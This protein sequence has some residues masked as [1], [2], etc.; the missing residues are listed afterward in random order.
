MAGEGRTPALSLLAT[1]PKIYSAKC[2]TLKSLN[3]INAILLIAKKKMGVGGRGEKNPCL[4]PNHKTYVIEEEH[5]QTLVVKKKTN[6]YYLSK[7]LDHS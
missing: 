3:K 2:L 4:F 5:N 7:K 1:L 6:R